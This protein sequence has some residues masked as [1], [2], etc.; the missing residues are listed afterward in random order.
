ME[1][2]PKVCVKKTSPY[3]PEPDPC[4]GEECVLES[5]NATENG[6][7]TPSEEADGFDEV[8]VAVPQPSQEASASRRTAQSMSR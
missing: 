3:V 1:I 4:C 6:V 5:L 2:M 7:Y 8:T